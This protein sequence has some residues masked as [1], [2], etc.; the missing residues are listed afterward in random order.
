M[1]EEKT[2]SKKWCGVA[3]IILIIIAISAIV[4]WIYIPMKG[5][6]KKISY[7][8]DETSLPFLYC[9]ARTT[10]DMFFDFSGANNVSQTVK[11]VFD[12]DKM[13]AISYT[14]D[15][16]YDNNET[17]EKQGSSY[18][19]NYYKYTTGRDENFKGISYHFAVIDNRA[20]VDLYAE[21]SKLNQFN[22]KLFSLDS[23]SDGSFNY[24][25]DNLKALYENKGY[26]CRFVN[27]EQ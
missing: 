22:A 12:G 4:Y 11:A 23:K 14:A 18:H 1:T 26:T 6:E 3:A 16:S 9:I 27:N 19:H 21:A 25:D 24:S 8:Q 5:D 20:K 13:D 2:N 15:V 10:D 7:D 17:A